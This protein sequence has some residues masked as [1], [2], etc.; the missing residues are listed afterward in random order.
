M[1]NQMSNRTGKLDF[2]EQART[3]LIAI[4]ASFYS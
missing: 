1:K 2:V 3:A 4:L